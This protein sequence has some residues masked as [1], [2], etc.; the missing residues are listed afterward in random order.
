MCEG[1]GLSAWHRRSH[2]SRF[3]WTAKK[4]VERLREIAYLNDYFT[5]D[6][7]SEFQTASIWTWTQDN[8]MPLSDRN[9]DKGR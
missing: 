2:I 6:Q 3:I 4:R 7:P 5:L 1:I 8:K 9:S